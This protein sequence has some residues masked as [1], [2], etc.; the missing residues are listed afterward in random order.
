MHKRQQQPFL[1]G[2]SGKT[3][4]KIAD[5][6]WVHDPVTMEKHILFDKGKHFPFPEHLKSM[7]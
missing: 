3:G 7:R 4:S 2:A 1:F 6:V 5:T